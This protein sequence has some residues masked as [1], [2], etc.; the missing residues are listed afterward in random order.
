M[1]KHNRSINPLLC[2]ALGI[3]VSYYGFEPLRALVQGWAFVLLALF[4]MLFTALSCLRVMAQIPPALSGNAVYPYLFRKAHLYLT[5]FSAGLALGFVPGRIQ[6]IQWGM[7]EE[8]IEGLY[9]TILDDPR[10]F[11]DGRGMA[12]L[13]ITRSAVRGGAI[14]SARG[15]ILVFFPQG[16]LSGLKEFGR[17]ARIYTEGVLLRD[18]GREPVFSSRS[19]HIL[20]AAPPLEQL[21]TGVR[22]AVIEKLSPRPAGA[23]GSGKLPHGKDWT[24]LALALILGVRDNLDAAVGNSF[25]DAGC[26]HVLALSGMHLAIISSLIAFFLKKP[27]GVKAASLLGALLIICYVFLAG[28]QPSLLRSAIMYLLGTLAVWGFIKKDVSCLL[29]LSFIVQLVSQPESGRTLSFILSYLALAGILYLGEPVNDL[30]GGRLPRV[31]SGGI[32]ASLGAFIATASVVSLFFGTLRPIGIT[33]GLAVVP[34]ATVFMIGSLAYLALS[35]CMPYLAG[36]LGRGL[37][38]LYTIMEHLT[39]LAS[40]APGLEVPDAVPVLLVSLAAAALLL[41][42]AYRDREKRYT[43]APFR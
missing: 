35:F 11:E 38:L 7:N 26:S 31:L 25:R 21:R 17:G 28:V 39:G 6:P 37:S 42:F 13:E 22:A 24:G 14:T 20:K 9:G 1:V 4:F 5:A 23:D 30:L 33:A 29:C 18:R 36:I 27:L 40:R 3:A 41:F 12:R 15:N 16:S 43:L 8:R 2:A 10:G 19:L 32:S 34:L